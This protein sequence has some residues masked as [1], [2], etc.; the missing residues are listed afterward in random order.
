MCN[1]TV[2]A[3]ESAIPKY[4]VTFLDDEDEVITISVRQY[5]MQDA[6]QDVKNIMGSCFSKLISVTGEE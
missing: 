6:V 3:K 2:P 4:S 5:T 1:Y